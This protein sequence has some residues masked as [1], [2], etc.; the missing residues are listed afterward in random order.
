MLAILDHRRNLG[1]I[2]GLCDCIVVVL[3][4]K[5]GDDSRIKLTTVFFLETLII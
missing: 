4:L 2:W 1:R 3:G 5:F